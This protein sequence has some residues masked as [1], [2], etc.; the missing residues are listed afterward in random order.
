MHGPEH[1]LKRVPFP[2]RKYNVHIHVHV[3][4][5]STRL[6]N[7]IFSA[8]CCPKFCSPLSEYTCIADIIM[9]SQ[10]TSHL[11]TQL[12]YIS[13]AQFITFDHHRVYLR[14]VKCQVL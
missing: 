4:E 10:C 13:S 8:V 9:D 1:L 3:T 2:Q 6:I 11:E 5:W 7:N 14:L 12:Y